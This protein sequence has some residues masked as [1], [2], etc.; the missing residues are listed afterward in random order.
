MTSYSFIIVGLLDF[1]LTEGIF[2]PKAFMAYASRALLRLTIKVLNLTK[3]ST[4]KSWLNIFFCLDS[5]PFSSSYASWSSSSPTSCTIPSN[6]L[7]TS[8]LNFYGNDCIRCGWLCTQICSPLRYRRQRS[9]N[10]QNR[11]C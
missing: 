2:S 1:S 7:P 8:S 3:S 10:R 5:R 9:G 4:R 11:G 6:R